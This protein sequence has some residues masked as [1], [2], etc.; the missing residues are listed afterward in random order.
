MTRAAIFDIDGTLVDSVD[1][2]AQ[3][4]AETLRHF[5]MDVTVERLR[6][7]IGKGADQFLPE[8]LPG[9][10]L[11]AERTRIA[12]YRAELLKTNY[13]LRVTAFA[14]VPDLFRRIRAGGSRIVLASSSDAKEVANYAKIAGIT[15]LVDVTASAADA[16]ASKPSPD[17]FAAAIAKIAPIEAA[18]AIVIG[19]S[20]W[21]IIAAQRAG[22]VAIGLTCGAF[23]ADEL[24]E[25]GAL[26]TY[27]HP[28]DLLTNYDAS[29]FAG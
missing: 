20:T 16:E 7:E 15:D 14:G 24:R 4:W 19:D 18:D 21:D 3:C 11:E 22:L 1:L 13:V 28:A 10:T 29:P 23:S 5:H 27:S 17:I 9:E 26:A 25:A 12:T 6:R 2:H 8:F